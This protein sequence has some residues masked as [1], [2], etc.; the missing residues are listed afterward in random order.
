MKYL[1][2][3]NDDVLSKYFLKYLDKITKK[4]KTIIFR[5]A[6]EVDTEMIMNHFKIH[7][8]LIVQPTIITFSQYNLMVMAL[9]KLIKTGE[10][11]DGIKEIH[12]YHSDEEL[13]ETLRYLWDGKRMY[14]DE[15]LKHVKI[16]RVEEDVKQELHI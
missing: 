11:K 13:D 1:V 4:K 8:I 14:L 12:L 15:V 2:L 9:Y 10:L 16:F 6:D 7:Q 5:R 3:E